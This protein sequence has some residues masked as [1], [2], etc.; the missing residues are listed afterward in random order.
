MK[1]VCCRRSKALNKDENKFA[2]S[3]QKT[4]NNSHGSQV[5]GLE[6]KFQLFPS[7]W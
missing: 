6:E 2:F 7:R 4:L 3:L 1:C 5:I